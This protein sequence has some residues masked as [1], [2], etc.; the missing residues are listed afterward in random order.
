MLKPINFWYSLMEQFCDWNDYWNKKMQAF[1]YKLVFAPFLAYSAYICNLCWF[2]SKYVFS[3]NSCT[4]I[5]NEYKNN[6]YF[7]A[8]DGT[9]Y[10]KFGTVSHFLS[11]IFFR[12]W[13][14]IRYVFSKIVKN[15]DFRE[16][17]FILI[18]SIL[19]TFFRCKSP[20]NCINCIKIIMQVHEFW[21]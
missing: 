6:S 4:R 2:L 16:A 12:P 21:E 1:L 8:I 20:K 10:E 11:Y 9:R 5:I 14:T 7:D 17:I 13:C 15:L 18:W 19:N 3:Q